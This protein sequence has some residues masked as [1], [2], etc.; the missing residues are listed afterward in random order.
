MKDTEENNPVADLKDPCCSPEYAHLGSHR[1][2][3]QAFLDVQRCLIVPPE[4]CLRFK[5]AMLQCEALQYRYALPIADHPSE[6]DRQEG[7]QKKLTRRHCTPP[8]ACAANNTAAKTLRNAIRRDPGYTK[9]K[10]L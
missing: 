7:D 5:Q 2:G 10:P 3:R 9:R 4:T 8:G 1:S 6:K